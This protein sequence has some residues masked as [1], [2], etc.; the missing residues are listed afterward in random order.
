MS[1]RQGLFTLIFDMAILLAIIVCFLSIVIP[2]YE[3]EYTAGLIEKV[4]KLENTKGP[5]I[6]LIGNSNL[7][8]GINSEK[9]EEEMGMPVI[10]MGLHGGLGNVFAEEMAKI[11]VEAGDIYVI[12]HS[13]Y[14]DDSK[15]ID[16][17][18]R[19]VTIED[20]PQLWKLVR[21]Q[22]I[23]NMLEVFPVYL[24]R[25]IALWEEGK[26]NLAPKEGYYYSEVFNEYGDV[27]KEREEPR[28][29]D[30][31]VNVEDLTL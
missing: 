7:A 14:G 22:D 12:C 9:I 18:L 31:G 17:V 26:G 28:L 5:K 20:K 8:F 10:N 11:N 4:E 13:D 16:W 24:K 29:D 19:W 27:A 3:Q 21:G 15:E 23:P 1:R 6:V 2:E 25:C 30:F